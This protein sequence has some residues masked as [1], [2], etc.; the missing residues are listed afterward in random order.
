M[1]ANFVVIPHKQQ[2]YETVGDWWWDGGDIEFRVSK[3]SQRRYELLVFLHE[4]IGVFLCS[5]AS[6]MTEEVDEWDADYE[7][8]RKESLACRIGC[9]IT[10]ISEPGD[11]PHAPYYRQ[12]QLIDLFRHNGR[13]A[14]QKHFD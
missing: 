1:R 7:R 9:E 11:D 12:H 8:R 6:V 2:R 14:A 4:L 10:K 13:F 3:L 5:E